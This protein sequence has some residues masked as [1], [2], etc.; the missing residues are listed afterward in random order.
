MTIEEKPDQRTQETHQN[1]E[2]AR[3][4]RELVEE[5]G[6]VLT[7]EPDLLKLFESAVEDQLNVQAKERIRGDES[8]DGK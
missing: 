1:P 7:E 8:E 4:R 3:S 2:Q 5:L 6:K